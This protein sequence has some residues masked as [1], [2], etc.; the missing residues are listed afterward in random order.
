MHRSR[1]TFAVNLGYVVGAA[2][3]LAAVL[4]AFSLPVRAQ[5]QYQFE[6]DLMAKRRVF[7]DVGAGFREIRR[8]TNGNYFVLT[9]PAPAVKIYDSSGKVIGQVPSST[10]AEAKGAA[11]VYGESFDVDHDGRVVV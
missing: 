10:A 2:A 6:T 5:E 1:R 4:V 8:G 11:L 3:A 9:A 7:R